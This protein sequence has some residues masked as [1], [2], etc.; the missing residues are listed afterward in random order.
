MDYFSGGPSTPQTNRLLLGPAHLHCPYVSESWL[1][2]RLET[3]PHSQ[4]PLRWGGREPLNARLCGLV[5]HQV[6]AEFSGRKHV[7][8]LSTPEIIFLLYDLSLQSEPHCGCVSQRDFL[9]P[10]AVFP[11][12]LTHA[13]PFSL[14]TMLQPQMQV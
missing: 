8:L 2:F 6:F 9:S 4:R 7:I 11:L 1:E 3:L 14:L 5:G 10:S 13:L 12:C